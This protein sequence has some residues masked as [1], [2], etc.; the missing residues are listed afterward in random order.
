MRLHI[1]NLRIKGAENP[2]DFGMP[3]PPEVIGE[4]NAFIVEPFGVIAGTF[5]GRIRK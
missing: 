4:G 5:T 3:T 2:Y 1:P